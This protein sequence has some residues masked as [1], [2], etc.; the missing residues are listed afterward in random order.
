MQVERVM[1]TVFQRNRRA[2]EVYEGKCGWRVDECSPPEEEEKEKKRVRRLRGRKVVVERKA[3]GGY[4][5]MS[6]VLR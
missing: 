2:R 6:K 5:I 1:L 3:L 4:V